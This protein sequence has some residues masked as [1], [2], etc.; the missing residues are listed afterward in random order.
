M[1]GLEPVLEGGVQVQALRFRC[2]DL[3]VIVGHPI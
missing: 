1:I 2:R 3:E